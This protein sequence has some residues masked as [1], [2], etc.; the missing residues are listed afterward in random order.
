M[1]VSRSK[2]NY[3]GWYMRETHVFMVTHSH[4]SN[5]LGKY[6]EPLFLDD[7][8]GGEGQWLLYVLACMR[9]FLDKKTSGWIIELCLL[10]THTHSTWVVAHR[11][12]RK[13]DF[14][15]RKDTYNGRRLFAFYLYLG[16]LYALYNLVHTDTVGNRVLHT[17]L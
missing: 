9:N 17:P 10:V 8:F 2:D 16:Q 4:P 5:R 13:S 7:F 6:I 3:L 12:R 11:D 1:L 15:L 14:Y